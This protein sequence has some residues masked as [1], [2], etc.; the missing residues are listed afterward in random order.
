MPSIDLQDELSVSIH[1]RGWH[2][3]F[4]SVFEFLTCVDFMLVL[5]WEGSLQPSLTAGRRSVVVFAVF[6]VSQTWPR[7]AFC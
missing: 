7:A 4:N 1:L 2:T 6:P 5:L 3:S